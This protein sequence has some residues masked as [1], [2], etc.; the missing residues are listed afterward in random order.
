MGF[1]SLPVRLPARGG[2]DGFSA[3]AMCVRPGGAGVY[4]PMIW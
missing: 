2:G 3:G 4:I 1:P